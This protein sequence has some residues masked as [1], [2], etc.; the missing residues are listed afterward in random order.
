M[1]QK[2]K[3]IRIKAPEFKLIL[4]VKRTTQKELAKY[5]DIPY[6]TFNAYARGRIAI[7]EDIA[8]KMKAYLDC[9]NRDLFEIEERK[10]PLSSPES[11][12]KPSEVIHP[13]K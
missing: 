12:E 5:L 3:I 10:Q 4:K 11:K 13:S 9:Q 2:R 1:T 8:L 7:P 6:G